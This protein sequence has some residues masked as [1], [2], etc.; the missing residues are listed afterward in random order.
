[1]SA[2]HERHHALVRHIVQHYRQKGG[3]PR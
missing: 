2:A 3:S 1:M